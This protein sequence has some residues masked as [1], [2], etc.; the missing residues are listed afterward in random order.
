MATPSGEVVKAGLCLQE[1]HLSHWVSTCPGDRDCLPHSHHFPQVNTEGVNTATGPLGHFST[2]SSQVACVFEDGPEVL[3]TSWEHHPEQ[4]GPGSPGCRADPW[5][6]RKHQLASPFICTCL[7][8]WFWI[9]GGPDPLI[10]PKQDLPNPGGPHGPL[11]TEVST[12]QRGAAC[13]DGSTPA[14]T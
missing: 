14:L 9:A 11:H 4:A 10:C 8:L 6:P 2:I 3:A 7:P 5:H 1:V 12:L 13:L